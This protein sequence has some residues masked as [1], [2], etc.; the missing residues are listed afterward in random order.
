MDL[1]LRGGGG[2][3]LR[4]PVNTC[5]SATLQ[6]SWIWEDWHFIGEQIADNELC[7]FAFC[8]LL[9]VQVP[10]FDGLGDTPG[11]EDCHP[12]KRPFAAFLR[13]SCTKS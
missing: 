7:R 11:P 13:L 2:L 10:T 8:F 9:I 12:G 4:I 6:D 1:L 3:Y 5:N